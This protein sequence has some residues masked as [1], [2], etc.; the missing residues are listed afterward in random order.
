MATLWE[1]NTAIIWSPFNNKISKI[2][3][4]KT[5]L[6]VGMWLAH[7]H[8]MQFSVKRKSNMFMPPKILL[9]SLVVLWLLIYFVWQTSNQDLELKIIPLHSIKEINCLGKC[10][11]KF[12]MVLNSKRDS[13][14]REDIEKS[15]VSNEFWSRPKYR[16][17]SKLTVG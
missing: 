12:P 2:M 16:S 4:T 17:F 9:F 14:K 13:W 1:M 8:S 15:F 5:Q 3:P 11:K 10:N 6:N 7:S